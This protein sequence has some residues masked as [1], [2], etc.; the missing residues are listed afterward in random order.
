[1]AWNGWHFLTRPTQQLGVGV[2]NEPLIRQGDKLYSLQGNGF[3]VHGQMYPINRRPQVYAP[4]NVTVV[5]LQGNGLHLSGQYLLSQLS[6]F[7][8]AQEQNGPNR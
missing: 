8:K 2:S 4:H 5:G 1:M 7:Q 3:Q 6:D